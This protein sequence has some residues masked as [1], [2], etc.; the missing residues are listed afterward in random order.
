MASY[1]SLSKK[2][3]ENTAQNLYTLSVVPLYD[4]WKFKNVLF[5]EV[6]QNLVFIVNNK[7]GPYLWHSE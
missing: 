6:F 1:G 4:E 3:Y 5:H 2:C 7:V